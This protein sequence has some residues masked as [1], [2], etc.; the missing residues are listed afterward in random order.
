MARA[1]SRILGWGAADAELVVTN[2][3]LAAVVDSSDE[4]IVKRTGIRQR[5]YVNN[6]DGSVAMGE[7]ASRDALAMAATMEPGLTLSR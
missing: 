4:W 2:D 1:T 5:R 3:E 6:G 7:K